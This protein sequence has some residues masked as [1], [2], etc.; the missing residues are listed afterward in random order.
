MDSMF[1]HPFSNILNR[2]FLGVRVGCVALSIFVVKIPNLCLGDWMIDSSL[3]YDFRYHLSSLIYCF[4]L[5]HR[6]LTS[7]NLNS[8]LPT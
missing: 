6:L 1:Y 2:L 5:N 7:R 8:A 3:S 4:L